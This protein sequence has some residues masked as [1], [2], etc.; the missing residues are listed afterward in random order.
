MKWNPFLERFARCARDRK[1]FASNLRRCFLWTLVGFL[2]MRRNNASNDLNAAD[3]F[4]EEI[5]RRPLCS[6]GKRTFLKIARMRRVVFLTRRR[7]ARV[8]R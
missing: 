2:R 7:R 3:C 4:P 8:L 6:L 5:R 1:N